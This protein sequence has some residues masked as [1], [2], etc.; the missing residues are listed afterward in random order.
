LSRL[1]RLIARQA[2]N[3]NPGKSGSISVGHGCER[4]ADGVSL[5]RPFC[6]NV[7]DVTA[8]EDGGLSGNTM[9]ITCGRDELS[10]KPAIEPPRADAATVRILGGIL[11]RAEGGCLERAAAALAG[12]ERHLASLAPL[13]ADEDVVLAEVKRRPLA[14]RGVAV[15]PDPRVPDEPSEKVIAPLVRVGV[16]ERAQFR[17]G[18]AATSM[19][20]DRVAL[21]V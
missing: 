1:F 9:E 8:E 16:G 18:G 4:S 14:R 5:A 3:K 11:L 10:Q 13:S 17:A 6:G 12:V 15:Q 21:D 7:R 19:R 2:R 20:D